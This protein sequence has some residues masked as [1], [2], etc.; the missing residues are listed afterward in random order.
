MAVFRTF[1][2]DDIAAVLEAFGVKGYVAHTPI[3][4]GTINTNIRVETA[5]PTYFLRVNEGKTEDE[6]VREA[7]IVAHIVEKGVPSPLPMKAAG[8]GN[9]RHLAKDGLFFSL[10]PWS[11][12]RT[13]HRDLVTPKVAAAAGDA[14]A[15]LHEAGADFSDHRPGRYEPE[16]IGRRFDRIKTLATAD[17]PLAGDAN[18]NAGL[19]VLGPALTALASSRRPDLPTGLIHGDLFIDN[20]LF[21]A[22][23]NLVALLD[24]EQAS[25]GRLAYDLAVTLLAFSYGRSDFDTDNTRALIDAYVKRRPPTEAEVQGFPDELA[26]AAC[27]FAVTRITDVH[28]KREDGAAPGKDYRRYLERLAAV[29][30]HH[31][32]GS[33]LLDLA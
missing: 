13:L 33:G 26:F 15:R 28:L 30:R 10:F 1:E 27:R 29:V 12:G 2:P 21:D 25:W 22:D 14:L 20:T 24:F 18:L 7:Q 4:A 16:E 9:Q 5:G 32:S 6:V 19:S 23:D 8:Q 17:G 3:A 31:Q 11:E